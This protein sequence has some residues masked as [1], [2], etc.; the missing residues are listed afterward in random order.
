ML[1][2]QAMRQLVAEQEAGAAAR[3]ELRAVRE[4]LQCVEADLQAERR[5]HQRAAA[6]CSALEGAFGAHGKQSAAN[7]VGSLLLLSICS[8]QHAWLRLQ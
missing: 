3:A 6:K 7:E 5:E 4:R 1:L 2:P 8:G